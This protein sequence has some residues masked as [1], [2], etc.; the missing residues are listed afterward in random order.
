MSTNAL[1]DHI[2]CQDVML[3]YAKGVDERDLALY[4]GYFAGD[5]DKKTF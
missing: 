4:R 5:A 1:A 2:A 3:R